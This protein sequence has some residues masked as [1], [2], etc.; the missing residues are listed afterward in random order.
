MCR[1]IDYS[2]KCLLIDTLF[3]RNVQIKES[4]L[5]AICSAGLF[6]KLY[7]KKKTKPKIKLI[8]SNFLPSYITKKRANSNYKYASMDT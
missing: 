4:I 1:V 7:N 5:W 8:P 2:H 3:V 6:F